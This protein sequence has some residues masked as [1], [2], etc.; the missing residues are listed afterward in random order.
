MLELLLQF[1]VRGGGSV[2]LRFGGSGRLGRPEHVEFE[3]WVDLGH[4]L[5]Q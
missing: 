5:I 3:T 1:R 2:R 4:Q